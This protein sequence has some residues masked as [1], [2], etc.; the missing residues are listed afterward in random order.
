[1]TNVTQS[2]K[3]IFHKAEN[4]VEKGENAGYRYFLFFPQRFQKP[5]SLSFSQSV[6]VFIFFFL[7]KF[8]YHVNIS[9]INK[10]DLSLPFRVEVPS[11]PPSRQEVLSTADGNKQMSDLHLQLP[12]SQAFSMDEK[13]KPSNI[14]NQEN[15]TGN[16][17]EIHEDNSLRIESTTRNIHVQARKRIGYLSEKNL[18]EHERNLKESE[19]PLLVEKVTKQDDE[20]QKKGEKTGVTEDT[21]RQDK[22]KHNTKVKPAAPIPKSKPKLEAQKR[23]IPSPHKVIQERAAPPPNLPKLDL[24]DFQRS[25][26]GDRMKRVK[27]QTPMR[28][29]I[30]QKS[31]AE[32]YR[33]IY[34]RRR[35]MINQQRKEVIRLRRSR[36]IDNGMFSKENA[37][38][39]FEMFRTER[40]KLQTLR[41]INKR[42]Y[43]DENEMDEL[44]QKYSNYFT[45]GTRERYRINA[46]NNIDDKD[47]EMTYKLNPDTTINDMIPA[48]MS[49]Y[50]DES[51]GHQISHVSESADRNMNSRFKMGNRNREREEQYMMDM[52]YGITG[53]DDET[54]ALPHNKPDMDESDDINENLK[55]RPITDRSEI[56]R[57]KRQERYEDLT[58]MNQQKNTDSGKNQTHMQSKL[59]DMPIG[60]EWEQNPVPGEKLKPRN[61][62]LGNKLTEDGDIEVNEQNDDAYNGGDISDKS[63]RLM[64]EF[65]K[66]VQET[67]YPNKEHIDAIAA[68]F[69]QYVSDQNLSETNRSKV[70]VGDN[71]RHPVTK[72]KKPGESIRSNR[73]ESAKRR[74]VKKQVSTLK[75]T[76]FDLNSNKKLKKTTPSAMATHPAVNDKDEADLNDVLLET[77]VAPKP[78]DVTIR[79][80]LTL[81]IDVVNKKDLDGDKLKKEKKKIRRFWEVVDSS[82]QDYKEIFGEDENEKVLVAKV[83]K[84]RKMSSRSKASKSNV[85]SVTQ[86]MGKYSVT[87][88]VA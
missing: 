73:D 76:P 71:K 54:E 21:H 87:V 16:I 68:S 2:I 83:K 75:K 56:S 14:T 33:E 86:P 42:M 5:F 19:K 7:S 12:Y 59:A 13:T 23:E 9:W 31:R 6:N 51:K 10:Y 18:K 20:A 40:R 57:K 84:E 82:R 28:G 58:E 32:S 36:S 78:E 80:K 15:F 62:T 1:M 66:Y 60:E 63:S 27:Q 11:H 67:S 37:D 25:P 64:A 77:D 45:R 26:V 49:H 65:D 53:T 70:T 46:G 52:T 35:S 85:S 61:E 81:E 34:D 29:P 24:P 79:D 3:V 39:V 47:F 50:H 88:E 4:I 22:L 72:V 55:E 38:K 69:D 74:P 41:A 8:F 43:S 17:K 48:S 30:L 44:I